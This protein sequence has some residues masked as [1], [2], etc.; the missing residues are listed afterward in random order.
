[1]HHLNG[2]TYNADGSLTTPKGK[3]FT[4]QFMAGVALD[5]KGYNRI[6]KP[7]ALLFWQDCKNGKASNWKVA[8]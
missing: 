8:Q 2:F 5:Y 1:M 6:Y 7:F 3:T 4:A